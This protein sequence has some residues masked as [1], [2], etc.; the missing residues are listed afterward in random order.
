[1]E[2]VDNGKSTRNPVQWASVNLFDSLEDRKKNNMNNMSRILT[3]RKK[4]N[5]QDENG[6]RSHA[7]RL[8]SI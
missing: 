6:E 4:E 2:K 8:K 5:K 7:Q 1:M 3:V